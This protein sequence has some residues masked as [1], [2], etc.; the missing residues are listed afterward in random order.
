ML[1]IAGRLGVSALVRMLGLWLEHEHLLRDASNRELALEV[2]SL[3]L[4]RWPA[5]Q[6]VEALLN[7]EK[8]AG[9]V[10][11]DSS[12]NG[13]APA[14]DSGASGD[15]PPGGKPPAGATAQERLSHALWED[16]HKQLASAV[17]SSRCSLDDGVLALHFGHEAAALAALIQETEHSKLLDAACRSLFPEFTKL[18]MS[19][20]TGRASLEQEA[21]A[22]PQVL[23]V[24]R[25]L[26]GEIVHVRPDGGRS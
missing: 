5:V 2:A 6:R 1:A 11:G 13:A 16:G 12:P 8:A 20:E 3:R 18:Q 15:A 23:L 9:P 24:Q 10:G 22:D 19:V 26:G 4:A 14:T 17:D 25:I 7:G 21:L